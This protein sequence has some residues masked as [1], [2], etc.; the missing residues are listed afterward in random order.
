[1]KNLPKVI[2]TLVSLVLFG[3]GISWSS[4]LSSINREI[5]SDITLVVAEVFVLVW[6]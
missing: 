1:M 2:S 5:W 3:F 4:E 6:L